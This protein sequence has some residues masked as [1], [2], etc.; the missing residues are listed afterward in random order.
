MD[1][2]LIIIVCLLAS[3]FICWVLSLID[4]FR[5]KNVPTSRE[6]RDEEMRRVDN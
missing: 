2:L 3:G 1:T 6:K 4:K 5:S